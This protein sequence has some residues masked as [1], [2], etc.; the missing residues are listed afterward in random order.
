MKHLLPRISIIIPCYNHGH[1]IKEAIESVELCKDKELYEII[2]INDGS[3][4]QLTID[5]LQELAERGYNVINQQNQG[6]GATRNNGIRQAEGDYILPLDSDNKIRSEYIYESI[7]ILDGQPEI[8]MVYGDAEYFEKVT[9]RHTIGE[10]NLQNMM[11]EN[12]IDACAVYRKS[13]WEN[14]GGYD[15]KMPVMGM[16]DW[17]LWLN[18][19]FNNYKFHYINKVMFDYRVVANSML[20]SIDVNKRKLL[21]SYM[22]EKYKG[23]LNLNHLN[24][25]LLKVG[26]R[27]KKLA[28]KFF[29]I[30]YFPRF[31]NYL[32]R[33][34]VL[35]TPDIF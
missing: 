6:L 1:Y 24:E 10:F 11:V 22:D 28:F 34:K 30:L 9:G 8:A 35:K 14:V 19:A 4:N 13:V 16:E 33:K 15:E 18:M 31:I 3:T 27:N 7:K 2:I 23:Y 26:K 29:L 17:D 20:R 5:I 32:V 12:H 21:F 25:E